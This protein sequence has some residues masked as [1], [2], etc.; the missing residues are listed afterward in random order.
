MFFSY[1]YKNK[2]CHYKI[3]FTS[4]QNYRLTFLCIFQKFL[5]DSKG[6]DAIDHSIF[7]DDDLIA[8][9]KRANRYGLDIDSDASTLD[10]EL[11]QL[12]HSLNITTEDDVRHARFDT[13]HVRGTEKMNTNDVFEY[14]YTHKPLFLE[15]ID[16]NS[17]N[18]LFGLL[19]LFILFY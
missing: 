1:K 13:I 9:E 8:M 10:K 16:E 14:F 18:L 17:C 11:K 12:Y 4:K 19:F 6:K 2:S 3:I 7:N 15:W 5:F